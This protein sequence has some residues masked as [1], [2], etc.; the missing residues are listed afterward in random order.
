MFSNFPGLL[1]W[2]GVFPLPTFLFTASQTISSTDRI[3]GKSGVYALP[4]ISLKLGNGTALEAEANSPVKLSQEIVSVV[5]TCT[6]DYP[7]RWEYLRKN[8]TVR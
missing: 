2:I 4:E 3:N 5:L 8:K 6:A 7:V 1:F